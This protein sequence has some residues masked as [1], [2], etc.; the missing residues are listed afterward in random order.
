MTD[1][2]EDKTTKPVTMPVSLTEI[3]AETGIDLDEQDL[4]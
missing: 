2:N 4:K 3:G 1:H